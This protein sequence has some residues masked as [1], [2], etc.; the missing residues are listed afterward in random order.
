MLFLENHA[1][2]YDRIVSFLN[3]IVYDR[4]KITN[5]NTIR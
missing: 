3:V 2:Q 1:F 5:N 4:F